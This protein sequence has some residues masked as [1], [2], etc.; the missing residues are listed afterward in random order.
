MEF[1]KQKFINAA[2]Y[3]AKHTDPEKL[4]MVKL[5]KL[6]YYSDFNHYKAYGR[7]ITGDSYK[8][9][10]NG[11][12]PNT[13]YALLVNTFD[14]KEQV[15]ADEDLKEA[16]TVKRVKMK[17]PK[18]NPMEKFTPRKD[19]DLS[20]FSKSDIRVLQWAAEQFYSAS[21]A[22]LSRQSH[23][24]KVWRNTEPFAF[25]DY[26]R[27]LDGQEEE[28]AEFWEKENKKLELALDI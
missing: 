10:P 23:L 13:A 20:H 12:L 2:L 15:G 27:V 3:L 1:N 5:V 6:L 25:I 28:Y 21:G 7:P 14:V 26:K 19:P 11:P 18:L 8:R 4:G 22:E 24:D 16:F 17:D 9:F